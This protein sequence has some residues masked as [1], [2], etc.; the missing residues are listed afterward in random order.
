MKFLHVGHPHN[1]FNKVLHGEWSVSNWC[2]NNQ[3][4]CQ[5]ANKIMTPQSWQIATNIQVWNM[6]TMNALSEHPSCLAQ[7]T[8]VMVWN[9]ST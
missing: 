7:A 3:V 5:F 4:V 2:H 8:F 1:G 9:I 6:L